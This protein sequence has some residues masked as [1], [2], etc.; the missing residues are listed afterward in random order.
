[1]GGLVAGCEPVDADPR[2]KRIRGT[3]LDPV[4][5]ALRQVGPAGAQ[6]VAVSLRSWPT[7][8]ASSGV[9]VGAGVAAGSA[10]G[11]GLGESAGA[12][13]DPAGVGWLT[14]GVGSAAAGDADGDD[15][16]DVEHA[17]M[18]RAIAGRRRAAGRTVGDLVVK[19]KSVG[20]GSTSTIDRVLRDVV[21]HTT[22][23]DDGR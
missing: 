1:M 9:I 18:S 13:G 11:A 6:S 2:D 4:Q 16:G 12:D 17:A 19:R 5:G 21:G 10:D 23:R 8:A 15:D 22:Y 20:I 7:S 14:I 3:T